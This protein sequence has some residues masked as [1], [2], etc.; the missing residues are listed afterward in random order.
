MDIWATRGYQDLGYDI[1]CVLSRVHLSATSMLQHRSL[2]E[3][4]IE[5]GIAAAVSLE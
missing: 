1:H 4:A 3:Q 2:P 5:T